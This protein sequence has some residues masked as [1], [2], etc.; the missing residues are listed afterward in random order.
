MDITNIK[1]VFSVRP[2][3]AHFVH[4]NGHLSAVRSGPGRSCLGF[5]V[6]KFKNSSDISKCQWF[7]EHFSSVDVVE[8]L[9]TLFEIF[10]LS[11]GVNIHWK[12]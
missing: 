5:L 1:K 9:T 8:N 6:L 11:L 7:D 12:Q 2:F 10:Y 4:L 3:G